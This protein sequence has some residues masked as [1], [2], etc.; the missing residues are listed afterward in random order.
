MRVT[1]EFGGYNSRRY[2]RPWIAKI[3]TWPIG[4]RPEL[5]FGSNVGAYLVEIDAKPGAIVR[6]GQ[7]D[8]RG[9]NTTAEW[10]VVQLDGDIKDVLAETARE[11]W[12]AGCPV[13]P[14]AG[15]AE[16]DNIIQFKDVS[17]P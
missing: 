5:E 8:H 6:W 9:N 16:G 10:G 2:G 1:V 15:E 3:V 17:P 7:K 11:H 12:L 13:P 4:G 14:Q